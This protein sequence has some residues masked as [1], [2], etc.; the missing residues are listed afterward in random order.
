MQRNSQLASRLSLFVAVF[1]ILFAGFAVVAWRTLD[2]VRVKGP[3]YDEIILGNDLIADILPPPQYIIESY[4]LTLQLVEEKDA[5]E[6]TRLIERGNEL[7]IEYENRQEHWKRTLAKDTMGDHMTVTSYRAA[8]EFY[9]LRDGDFVSAIRAGDVEAARKVLEQMGQ[10]YEAHRYAID[11]V[12]SLARQRNAK[13]EL[14]AD[15]LIAGQTRTLGFLALGIVLVVVVM[16]WFA[17]RAA[18]TLSDRVQLVSDVA[19][20]VAQGDLTTNVPTTDDRD[21][22][23]RLLTAISGMTQSLRNLVTRVKQ[24]S[25]ELMSSRSRRSRGLALRPTRSP[26]PS[27]RLQPPARSCW[28][29]W[30]A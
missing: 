12:V 5:A 1:L 28:R 22:T 6:R 4:L 19:D 2:Q 3:L 30:K 9:R 27:S 29:R 14:Q 10:R 7:R 15:G 26:R 8:M 16:A 17:R 20:R 25:V 11:E 24:A 23:G 13:F 18:S 21:E